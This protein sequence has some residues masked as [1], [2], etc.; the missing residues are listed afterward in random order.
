MLFKLAQKIKTSLN[1]YNPITFFIFSFLIIIISIYFKSIN[2]NL[3]FL[4]D[5]TL[6]FSRFTEHAFTEN[7][8]NSLNTNYLGGHYYRPLTLI[9]II[10]N[11]EI[12]N[13]SFYIYHLS[14][15]F[16]HILTSLFLL[17][18]LKNL[19][20]GLLNSFFAV[21]LFSIAPIHINAVGWIAGRGDLLTAFF[22]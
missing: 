2:Y 8:I 18:I 14:N 17:F 3:I 13:N 15:L 9:S 21:L 6:V 22:L 12:A 20:Y 19:G 4:D 10:L 16:L 5:D 11:S 1:Q 7:I